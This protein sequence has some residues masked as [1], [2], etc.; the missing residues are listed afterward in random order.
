MDVDGVLARVAAGRGAALLVAG[1]G[2][3]VDA[4]VATQRGLADE[5]VAGQS[6]VDVVG[7]RLGQVRDQAADVGAQTGPTCVRTAW[8]IPSSE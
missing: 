7:W 8:V 1:A 5:L 4:Q 2:L 6:V 3:V